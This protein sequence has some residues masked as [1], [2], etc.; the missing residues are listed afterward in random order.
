MD[1]GVQ[2]RGND[3]HKGLSPKEACSEFKGNKYPWGWRKGNKRERTEK[4]GVE[5]GVRF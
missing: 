4:E 1:Q 5:G 3:K 2:G